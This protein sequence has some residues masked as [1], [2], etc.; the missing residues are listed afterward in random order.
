MVNHPA[1]MDVLYISVWKNIGRPKCL[2]TV[3]KQIESVTRAFIARVYQDR[4][5]FRSVSIDKKK[6]RGYTVVG[7]NCII[8]TVM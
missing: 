1:G 3:L 2:D 5:G 7:N 4:R 6:C 8:L